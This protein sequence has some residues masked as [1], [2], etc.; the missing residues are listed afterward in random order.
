MGSMENS[1]SE[2]ELIARIENTLREANEL[3]CGDLSKEKVNEAYTLLADSDCLRKI[4]DNLSNP[5][6]AKVLLEEY[7][8][9]AE[10]AMAAMRS[11]LARNLLNVAARVERPDDAGEARA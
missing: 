7:Q 5:E 1:E 8:R 3:L 2:S 4:G 11:G 10:K 6:Q 9:L